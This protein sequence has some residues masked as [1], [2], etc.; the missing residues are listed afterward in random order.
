MTIRVILWD[1]AKGRAAT[2]SSSASRVQKYLYM[3][4]GEMVVYFPGSNLW[5]GGW[6]YGTAAVQI[7]RQKYAAISLLYIFNFY[8]KFV[9]LM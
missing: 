5:G 4:G 7:H 8:K 2:S 1:P 9:F 3:Y 6:R